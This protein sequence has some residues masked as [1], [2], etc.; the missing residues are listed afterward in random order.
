MSD[1]VK[2]ERIYE[3]PPPDGY[4]IDNGMG[5]PTHLFSKSLGWIKTPEG[6]RTREDGMASHRWLKDEDGEWAWYEV[7]SLEMFEEWSFDSVCETPWGDEV[8]PD[9]PH[10]WLRIMGMI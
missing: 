8:E 9:H 10:S 6:Y 2:S 4:A 7:P 5:R 3:I 1:Q